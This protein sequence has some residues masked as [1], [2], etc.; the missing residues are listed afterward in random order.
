MTMD[1]SEDVSL[2]QVKE[3]CLLGVV[4]VFNWMFL[5]ALRSEF[6]EEIWVRKSSDLVVFLEI[7]SGVVE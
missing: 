5:F 7:T 1:V 2:G 6:L 4:A 3:V